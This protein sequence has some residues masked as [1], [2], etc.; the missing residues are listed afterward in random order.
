[1]T[2]G[3]E[4]AAGAAAVLVTACGSAPSEPA[5]AATDLRVPRPGPT[6]TSPTT[7]EPGPREF[8]VVATGDVLLHD[9]LWEQARRDAEEVG[10]DRD[11][12]F[13]PQLA[14]IAPIVEAADL[15][16][17]HLEVPIAPQGGPYHGYPLFSGPPEIVDALVDTGYG[18]CTVASNHIF[19][20][21]AAG[22]DRTL[23]A[24]DDAALAHAGAARTEAE[25]DEPVLIEIATDGGP[26][27]VGLVS[28]TF[29]F[30]GIPY[31]SGETWRS[32]LIDQDCVWGG[33]CE[34][35]AEEI[36]ADA[37]AAREAGADVVI[38]AM[39]WGPEFQAEP[40]ASQT[41]LAP[42]LIE[43]ADVDL[44]L[45]HHAHVVQPVEY[46]DGQWVVYG[47]GNLMAAH[48]TVGEELREGLLVRFT[49]TEDPDAGGFETTMAEY[50]PLLQTDPYP[51]RVLDVPA[52]P[53]PA[54]DV[55]ASTDRLQTAH[56]RTTEIVGRRGAFEH[57]LMLL[58]GQRTSEDQR[59]ERT[60]D[61]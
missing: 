8:T 30:N 16:I 14:A 29:S 37:A 25:A 41:S 22:V 4:L 12:D 50:L 5:P 54:D 11:L 56:D 23:D 31:P 51:A 6:V 36:L 9:P 33:S 47:L 52:A 28:Y 43:S 27:L 46:F 17:C 59:S 45:G 21:G 61:R 18:A 32:N 20:Q 13:A 42:L 7:P 24:L 58:D 2:R 35:A 1:M 34:R 39:H 57:G 40:D 38:A 26:A 10:G 15:G 44:V 3:R 19:D 55:P 49:F 48:A 53:D 60:T